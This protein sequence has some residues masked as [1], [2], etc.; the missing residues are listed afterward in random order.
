MELRLSRGIGFSCALQ[1]PLEK[2]DMLSLFAINFHTARLGLEAQNAMVFRFLRLVSSTHKT[3]VPE[4]PAGEIAVPTPVQ[5]PAQVVTV[6]S[7]RAKRRASV[8]KVHKKT[9]R[10]KKPTKRSK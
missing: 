8:S 9:V 2:T 1:C 6:E 4:I 5:A 3:E 7:D 10:A